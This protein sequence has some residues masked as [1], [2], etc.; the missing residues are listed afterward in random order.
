MLIRTARSTCYLNH[1]PAVDG[2]CFIKRSFE[3]GQLHGKF[4]G[5]R[6]G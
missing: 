4:F 2:E 3:F 6:K 1:T 5:R